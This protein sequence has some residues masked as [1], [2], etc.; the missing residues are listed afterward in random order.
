[1]RSGAQPSELFALLLFAVPLVFTLQKLLE[2]DALTERSHTL[3]AK[4]Q[5][6]T[7]LFQMCTQ[8][9]P[10]GAYP[11]FLSLLNTALMSSYSREIASPVR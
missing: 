1:M 6:S 11:L 5:R 10:V 4:A 9:K 2:F 7:A 8:E 3:T